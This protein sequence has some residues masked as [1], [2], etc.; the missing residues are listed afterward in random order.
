M[1]WDRPGAAFSL[2]WK[3]P[4]SNWT[5][6]GWYHER[7]QSLGER[8]EKAAA[9][10]AQGEPGFL[11]EREGERSTWKGGAAARAGIL[12][13]R[14]YEAEWRVESGGLVGDGSCEATRRPYGNENQGISDCS[15]NRHTLW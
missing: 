15:G 11:G 9:A 7:S 13:T 1:T 3:K 2:F 12:P 8:R 4:T 6:G 5:E 10:S 14:D